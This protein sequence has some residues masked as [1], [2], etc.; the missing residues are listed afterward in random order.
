MAELQEVS[1]AAGIEI[2]PRPTIIAPIAPVKPPGV[3]TV[4]VSPE[5]PVTAQE[6]QPRPAAAVARLGGQMAKGV[7]NATR[8]VRWREILRQNFAVLLRLGMAAFV[9]TGV[10]LLSAGMFL[11]LRV[12][13]RTDAPGFLGAGAGCFVSA[14]CAAWLLKGH[15]D[16]IWWRPVVA[17]AFGV[18]VGFTA[19]GLTIMSVRGLNDAPAF[20]GVGS[21]LLAF[22]LA[23]YL[24][25]FRRIG[26]D[27]VPGSAVAS[28]QSGP[29][30]SS[31]RSFSRSSRGI[32]GS[33]EARPI[34]WSLCIFFTLVVANACYFVVRI[35]DSWSDRHEASLH[36]AGGLVISFL[37][38]LTFCA[39]GYL[40]RTL[41]ASEPELPP[42]D[43]QNRSV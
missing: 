42:P 18:G 26:Q 21:G 33:I 29:G 38:A 19:A 24:L 40:L 23:A 14:I 36:L 10:G 13:E 8:R 22:G 15:R 28:P 43:L 6:V 3:E 34:L 5:R 1:R 35:L 12:Q 9:G 4:A 39:W 25:L 31:A 16:F 11:V 30:R 32:R 2:R 37:I 41:P 20:F 27:A 17:A 7:W